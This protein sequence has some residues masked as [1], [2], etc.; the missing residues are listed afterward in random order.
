MAD[1][2]DNDWLIGPGLALDTTRYFL[3]ATELFG[4]GH[5]SSPSNTPEPYHGPRFPRA[6][7]RDNVE[8]VHRLLVDEPARHPPGGGH[9]LLDGRRAGVS[10]GGELPRLQRPHR[11]DWPAR[12]GAG[13]TAECGSRRRSRRS[14]ATRRSRE[15]T[16]PRRRSRAS[17]SSA[18]SGPAGS[19]PR[20]GGDEELWKGPAWPPSDTLRVGGRVLRDSLLRRAD[21]NDL[22][23]QAR[24]G[25]ATTSARR[26]VRGQ[27]REGARLDPGAGALHA[28]ET[29]LYFP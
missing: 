12:P 1:H 8:A 10:V 15:A 28:V 23:L 11:R 19:T 22:I 14:R 13:P 7:I 2:H 18:W 27:H 21:A 9:R 3:V 25:S 4:N 5:S 16:T 26:R 17:G 20:S 24:P 6:T 29:D